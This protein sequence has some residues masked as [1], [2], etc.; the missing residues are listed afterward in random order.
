M[1]LRLPFEIG[2][3]RSFSLAHRTFRQ[4]FSAKFRY[5]N[6]YG[7]PLPAVF[8][9][10]FRKNSDGITLNRGSVYSI[11]EMIVVDKGYIGYRSSQLR[12]EKCH[13]RCA[14]T[15]ARGCYGPQEC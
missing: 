10:V 9:A 5:N 6:P 8:S 3:A 13:D 14:K 1:N 4:G 12:I 2:K 11:D 7:L 15:S